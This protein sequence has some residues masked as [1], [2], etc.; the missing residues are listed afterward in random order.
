MKTYLEN[1]L[2]QVCGMAL[3]IA[4]YMLLFGNVGA[5]TLGPTCTVNVSA[6]PTCTPGQAVINWTAQADA[7]VRLTVV[8]AGLV[9]G[10]FDLTAP[11]FQAA[12]QLIPP[13]AALANAVITFQSEYW[14]GRRWLPMDDQ[15]IALPNLTC[16]PNAVT[17]RT[18]TAISAGNGGGCDYQ[19]NWWP[20]QSCTITDAGVGWASGSCRFGNWFD[21]VR[22]IRTFRPGQDVTVAGCRNLNGELTQVR[23]SR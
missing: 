18:F 5:E 4:V 21:H 13:Q 2:I 22:T 19:R 3:A 17:L 15:V 23:I 8:H 16:G 11:A 20:R 9:A 10:P 14:T 1:A 6:V 12:G 7:P